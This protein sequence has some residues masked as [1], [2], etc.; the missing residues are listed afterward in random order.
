MRISLTNL[1]R[2]MAFAGLALCVVAVGLG[3]M[4]GDAPDLRSPR[5]VERVWVH[6]FLLGRPDPGPEFLDVGT[7][8]FW[9]PGLPAG[10]RLEYGSLAPWR[11][12]RGETQVVGR[13]ASR[14]GSD[15]RQVV[16]QF[17]L[18]R[19]SLPDGRALDRVPLS[20]LPVG[21]PCWF[22]GTSA[23]VL[24][25]AGDGR[26][27]RFAFEGPEGRDPHPQPLSWAEGVFPEGRIIL[28]DPSW[29]AEPRLGGRA[30]AVVSR[31][32]DEGGASRFDGPR[33]WWL[34]LDPDGARIEAAGPLTGP[35]TSDPESAQVLERHP[36][37]GPAPGGG[38]VLAYLARRLDRG[39]WQ[40]RVAPLEADARTGALRADI[41]AVRV[42][43]EDCLPV[44]PTFSADG[45][46]I[47]C[48]R[49]PAGS[50]PTPLRLPV[51]RLAP[52]GGGRTV[53]SSKDV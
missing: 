20:I 31:V 52:S 21:P 12:P 47:G 53:S 10:D 25:A 4:A 30:L 26:I 40:V 8:R 48:V 24:F 22:P 46:W 34:R 17:G 43:A 18:G 6:P 13:W 23:R 3:H 50:A 7:G 15:A 27:Y 44:P 9:R 28:G 14:S 33:I 51:P 19:F 41:A 1:I 38:L 11:G 36:M 5:H 49:Q 2:M 29:P 32:E 45:R 16:N 37:V 42:L 39:E 35:A